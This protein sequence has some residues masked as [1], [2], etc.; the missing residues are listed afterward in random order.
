MRDREDRAW[1][2]RFE[3]MSLPSVFSSSSLGDGAC[4]PESAEVLVFEE[5][6]PAVEVIGRVFENEGALE[7]AI[8]GD[9]ECVPAL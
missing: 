8:A 9:G 4:W 5:E 2:D 6:G 7:A 1:L 3:E